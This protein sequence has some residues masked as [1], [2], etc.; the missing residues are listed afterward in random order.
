M[1]ELANKKVTLKIFVVFIIL[2]FSSSKISAIELEVIQFGCTVNDTN[3]TVLVEIN[4]TLPYRVYENDSEITNGTLFAYTLA[5]VTTPRNLT[6]GII[7]T[8]SF[9]INYSNPA[10][11]NFSYSN[12][13]IIPEFK[14]NMILSSLVVLI[15]LSLVFFSY[16]KKVKVR[17]N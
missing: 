16:K 7:I 15:G 6:P 4:L 12:G 10:W 2:I 1:Q 14:T 3:V 17:V 11:L 8:H 9:L 5:N 13:P